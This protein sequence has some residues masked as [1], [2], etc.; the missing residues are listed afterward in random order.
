ML[1]KKNARKIPVKKDI[2]KSL[3]VR[4][5]L[6]LIILS[7]LGFFFAIY[8]YPYD[9][10][11]FLVNTDVEKNTVAIKENERI[12]QGLF[13]IFSVT[14]LAFY[15]WFLRNNDKL[16]QIKQAEESN[17]F[18]SFANATKFFL[19]KDNI[20]SNV[21]GLKLLI[22]IKNENEK[23]TEEIDLMTQY[24]KLQKAKLQNAYLSE[25]DLSGAD[26]SV[27]NLQEANLLKA[28]LDGA[29]LHGANLKYAD[30]RGTKL[31]KEHLQQAKSQGAILTDEDYEKYKKEK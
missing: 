29:N 20:E 26:L 5:K 9:F 21:V 13:F 28:V 11:N 22:K 4:R 7:L 1:D 23:F 3:L 10:L 19:E 12:L 27:A 14:P 2:V 16:E 30:L 24:K 17:L 15:L 8:F 31:E 25:A 6:I 18:N